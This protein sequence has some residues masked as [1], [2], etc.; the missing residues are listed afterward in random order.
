[1]P[2]KTLLITDFFSKCRST[3]VSNAALFEKSMKVIK[4]E[5]QS[6][7]KH[8]LLEADLDQCMPNLPLQPNTTTSIRKSQYTNTNY[9]VLI[10]NIFLATTDVHDTIKSEEDKIDPPFKASPSKS[11]I[12]SRIKFVRHH[13]APLHHRS[14]VKMRERL[15]EHQD[16]EEIR[17]R[18]RVFRNDLYKYK[19]TYSRS[20]IKRPPNINGGDTTPSPFK[21]PKPQT[22]IK[23]YKDEAVFTNTNKFFF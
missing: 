13:S 14:P 5:E 22:P 10:F 21:L 17:A 23:R 4:V 6:V 16:L 1:M 20:P 15:M 3:T 12:P 11:S 19:S 9:I 2:Q 8:D 18:I 7:I